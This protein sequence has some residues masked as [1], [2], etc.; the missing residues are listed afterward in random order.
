[1][2]RY[3]LLAIA[4]LFAVVYLFPV[5]WMYVT[6]LKTGGEIFQYPPAFWPDTPVLQ[7]W[8]VFEEHAIGRYIWNSLVVATGTT[9]ITV[10]LGTGAAYTLAHIRGFWP[11]VALFAIL[12]L[13]VLPPS[14]M[15]T[16]IFVAFNQFGVLAYPRLAVILATAAKTLPFYIILCRAAFTQ[17]PRELRDAALVDGN[18]HVGAFFHVMLPLARNGI[19]ITT[20]LVYLQS[21][22]EYVYSRSLIATR[23]LQTATVD[24]STYLG[25]NSNDWVGLMNYSSIYVTPIL[26]IFV[27]LQRQIVSGL[28]SGALK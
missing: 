13:Q 18:S 26:I 27:L 14:L 2:K 19:L 5:Y 7:V 16:P 22:G 20:V 3:L 28:T 6:A 1:M 4:I 9:A 15:V 10:I 21:F 17:V 23:E 25:A 12:V 24:L 8:K 11:N